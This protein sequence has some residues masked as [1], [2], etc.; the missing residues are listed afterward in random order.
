M[1]RYA[2]KRDAHMGAIPLRSLD[3]CVV[4]LFA[5]TPVDACVGF[6]H[7]F[8]RLRNKLVWRPEQVSKPRE[9]EERR[10]EFILRHPAQRKREIRLDGSQRAKAVGE[11]PLHAPSVN[12]RTAPACGELC[13]RVVGTC[14][15]PAITV[16]SRVG[17][18]RCDPLRCRHKCLVLECQPP[19]SCGRPLSLPPQRARTVRGTMRHDPPALESW[20]WTG[21]GRVRTRRPSGLRPRAGVV[22]LSRRSVFYSGIRTDVVQFAKTLPLCGGSPEIRIWL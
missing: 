19:A 18:K 13:Q 22:T 10:L 4:F 17:P 9:V 2:S 11:G 15:P 8:S 14:P 16:V 20:M 5:A 7:R 3:G 1:R 6:C 21:A 12:D